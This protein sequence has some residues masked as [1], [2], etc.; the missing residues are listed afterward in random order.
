MLYDLGIFRQR[1]L[2]RAWYIAESLVCDDG[3]DD[4]EDGGKDG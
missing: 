1:H 3:Y 2:F 4:E